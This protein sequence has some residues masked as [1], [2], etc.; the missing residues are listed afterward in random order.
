METRELILL[1]AGLLIGSGLTLFVW[2]LI[3]FKPS[4]R[5]QMRRSTY[6]PPSIEGRKYQRKYRNIQKDFDKSLMKI[7]KSLAK[8]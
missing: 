2:V 5:R 1:I 6:I 3:Q 4:Y 7:Q 8:Y